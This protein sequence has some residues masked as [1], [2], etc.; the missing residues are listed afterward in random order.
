VVLYH[1]IQIQAV[2]A[3]YGEVSGGPKEGRRESIIGGSR[4]QATKN[5]IYK[6]VALGDI[7]D[8]TIG[9][10][11]NRVQVNLDRV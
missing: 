5:L 6:S 2:L 3:T 1:H 11:K 10:I 9:R 7:K 4:S 8:L